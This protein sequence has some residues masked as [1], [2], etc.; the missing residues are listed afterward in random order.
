MNP[1]RIIKSIS[2]NLKHLTL[3][4][5]SV[6]AAL[7]GLAPTVHAQL[8][9]TS[10][11]VLRMDASQITG[12][13]NGTQLNTWTDSSGLANNAVRQGGS[14]AGYP[15]Y[16]TGALNGQPVVRFQSG[17]GNTGD[18]FQF[19][20]ISTIRT[21]FWVFKDTSSGS[22]FL[23]GDDS[24]YQFHR[25]YG[26]NAGKLWDSTYASGSITGGTTKL[27]GNVINGA[28]TSLPS[29][30]QLVSLVTTGNV[31]ANQICQDRIYNG[32]WQGDIAEIL[33]YNRALSGAEEL[34]VGTY[35]SAKYALTTT[36]PALPAPAAPTGV[37]ATPVSSGAV[38]V[39]WP[40]VPFAATYNVSYTP[41]LGGT[42]QIVSGV[43]GLSY[44]VTGL[45]NTVS[46]DIKVSATNTA[47]TSV[48]STTVMA[49]PAAATA[50]DILTFVFPGQQDTVISGTNISVTVPTGT[51]RN[52]A[53]TYTVSPSA[54]GSPVSGTTRNFSSA[55]TYTITA[56]DLSTKDYTVTVT[57]GPVPTI[58]TWASAVAGNW[59]DSAKWTNDL[60]I[61][62]KPNNDGRADYTLN[63]TPGGTYTTTQNLNNGF[64]LNQLNFAGAVTLAGN[65]SL[66]LTSNGPTPP[67]ISQNSASTVTISAPLNLTADTTL[68]GS[69][70]G[71]VSIN[72]GA[73]SG[74]G[75][76][77]KANSG[78]LL[79]T[80]V[81][82]YTGK[83]SVNAGTLR[84]GSPV[85]FTNAGVNGPLGAPPAGPNATIDL[86]N[87]TTLQTNGTTPRIN[88]ATD[89]P[90]NL[91]GTGP[92][93]VTIRVNDNDTRFTFGSVT[94][95]GTGDKTLAL[96]MGNNGNGDR[97]SMIFTGGIS[98]SSDSSPTSLSVTFR[99]G[100]S[101]HL[102]LVGTSTFTGPISMVNFNTALTGV[103]TLTVGGL[104]T[105]PNAANGLATENTRGTGSLG[106]GNYPGNISL[107]LNTV[108]NYRSS[109]AQTLSGE[110]SGAGTVTVDGLSTVT[111]TGLNTYT[112]N[113]NVP[114]GNTL[115]LSSTGGMTFALTNAS[116]NKITG[117]GTATLDGT[118]TINT[119][120]VTNP[121]GTWTL[122]DTTTKSFGANF[123]VDGF[124]EDTN[125]WTLV[126][127]TKTWTFSEGTG[128]LSLTTTAVFTSFGIPGYPGVIDNNALT[129]RLVVPKDTNLATI[130]PTYTLAS[131]TCTQPNDGT[132]PPTPTFAAANPVTYTLS[133][134]VPDKNYAVTV[135][136]ATGIIN[137]RV[138][139]GTNVPE[140]D[141]EGPAGP[142][143]PGTQ[144]WNQVTALPALAAS[145]LLDTVGAPTLVGFSASGLEGADDWGLNAP[146]KLLTRSARVFDTSP[147]NSGSFTIS[148]LTPDTYY[149]LWIASAHINGSGV[150][151]WSTSNINSTGAS[152]VIDNT[153]QSTNGTTWVS[154]VNYVRFQSVKVNGGGNITMTVMN[155][156][157]VDNRVGFNGF[158]L[159]P[160]EAPTATDYDDWMAT[161]PSITEPADKLSTADPDGDG[162]TNQEEYAFGLNPTLG[163]SVNPITVPLNKTTG[164]F[165]YTRRATPAITGLTYTVETS[166]DLAI[167][168]T[169]VTATQTVTGTVGD[170]QTVDVTVTG[171]P[172]TA[173][174]IFV[175]IKAAPTAP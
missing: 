101:Q 98:D 114:T 59:S 89:R 160:V 61:V 117:A 134:A 139:A 92:G 137:L 133:S 19:T 122:V 7:L 78:E 45:T 8:P 157:V 11:L 17:G 69:G 94:A 72:S 163:T 151:T 175:R 111:M 75:G 174:S 65:N 140:V 103:S 38:S 29:G 87:G 16:V 21:V 120:A 3:A 26:G 125:V 42:E 23:L 148:G 136:L 15:Q 24:T 113:T 130:A 32:S 126:D 109:V 12:T 97:E 145:G 153:G 95:S 141:L 68:G 143:V 161:F 91:A 170:V 48:Y 60:L 51:N 63:F 159:I 37:V 112:G 54:T 88:Q 30:F 35:L 66:A 147:G 96:F 86:Y 172:L 36:Y 164:M 105:G 56:E 171:A 41:T 46:Y 71:Q 85:A 20:R 102:S 158:Q 82:S 127:G 116:T 79:I 108:L 9:V 1:L 124:T 2:G 64:L 34:Q 44:T 110:I 107:G 49:T 152:V 84:I 99:T 25:G 104:F 168:P 80:N 27:M 93:T 43:S 50:K 146:L 76:L 47:G 6:A 135:V 118:F 83:T 144:T 81:N 39:S 10:G 14:S 58:F 100:N 67:A 131:G 18:Y 28:T 106:A 33:I 62:T 5:P 154:G 115:A 40:A 70:G 90:L 57:E 149:D 73:I 173:P 156:P 142:P 31:Q 13:A 22:R 167:W 155:N 166:T 119:S 165:T 74:V 129:I 132:T 162:L 123:A 121:T 128:V 150:G 77:T 52:M 138:S 4:V 169:D 55:Q 53:P